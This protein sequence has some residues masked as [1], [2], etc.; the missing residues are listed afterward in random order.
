MKIVYG[1]ENLIPAEKPNVIA[2]GVFDGVHVGHQTVIRKAVEEAG[3]RGV[4][5]VVITFDPHPVSILKPE[6]FLPILTGVELKAELVEEL[7]ADVFLVVGFTKEFSQIEPVSFADEVLVRLLK[8]ACVVVGEGFRFGKNA[9]GDVDFLR[10]YGKERNFDVIAVP[11]VLAEGKPIS[12]TRI[13]SLIAA[14]DL[15]GTKAILGRYPRFTGCVGK[16]FGRG[17]PVLGFPTANIETPDLASV[18]AQGV[19]AGWISLSPPSEKDAMSS[20]P[21][22]KDQMHYPPLA[23]DQMHYPPLEKGGQGGFDLI[24]KNQTDHFPPFGKATNHFPPFCKRGPGGICHLCVINIGTSPTFKTPSK[25]VEIHVHIPDLDQDLY[26]KHVEVEVR[27]RIRDEKS[28]RNKEALMRQIADD[29][30]VAK[31]AL[32]PECD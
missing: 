17:G 8:T 7:G 19:Y 31:K 1:V 15:E 12:S 14:G 18:P 4:R 24:K 11:L 29:I 16:G 22:A 21:L 2:I 20:P 28:F 32:S 6:S 9:S 25:K 26:E 30:E 10:G 3:K 23:K 27:L 5:A 13:R